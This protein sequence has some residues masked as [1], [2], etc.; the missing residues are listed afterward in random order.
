MHLVFAVI[1]IALLNALPMLAAAGQF[2]NSEKVSA[3]RQKSNLPRVFID[4]DPSKPGIQSSLRVV[5]GSSFMIDVVVSGIHPDKPL[6]GY[7]FAL[8]FDP[9]ILRAVVSVAGVFLP[10]AIVIENNA[11]PSDVNWAEG[12]LGRPGVDGGGI[13]TTITFEAIGNGRSNLDLTK[14]ILASRGEDITGRIRDAR[15]RVLPPRRKDGVDV[16]DHHD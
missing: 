14:V 15:V 16:A 8:H 10:G 1:M 9:N 13:L 2:T 4:T 11:T 6:D 3:A 7:E 12:V 5:R